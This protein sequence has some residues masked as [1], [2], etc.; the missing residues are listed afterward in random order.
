MIWKTEN[1]YI[2]RKNFGEKR[3]GT[4]QY[5]NDTLFFL[6]YSRNK[7]IIAVLLKERRDDWNVLGEYLPGREKEVKALSTRLG[8]I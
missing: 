5:N 2:E 8:Y 3:K 4:A 1:R 6:H 7:T